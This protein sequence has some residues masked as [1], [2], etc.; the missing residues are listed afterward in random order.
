MNMAVRY[1][2]NPITR[3]AKLGHG[4]DFA[5]KALDEGFTEVSSEQFDDFRCENRELYRQM[6]AQ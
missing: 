6:V 4:H 1:F 3:R 5:A 2:I